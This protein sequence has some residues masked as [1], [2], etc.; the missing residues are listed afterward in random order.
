MNSY[1]NKIFVGFSIA[2]SKTHLLVVAQFAFI[3]LGIIPFGGRPTADGPGIVLLGLG[4]VL[5]A[6][7]LRV[8][9]PENFNVSP[10]PKQGAQLCFEG[11]Y[12]FLRH[13]MYLA[14][15]LAVGGMA[16][17]NAS[18][19]NG[20]AWVL[21]VIVLD[22]KARLEEELLE[23]ESGRYRAYVDSTKRFIPFIY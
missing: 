6:W 11:P 3:L 13:P 14:V 7:T 20:V 8:N 17:C 4:L 15:M 10:L 23:Q 12:R 18:I 19:V 21:L 5:G 16:L 2:K 22:L 1:L 9:S